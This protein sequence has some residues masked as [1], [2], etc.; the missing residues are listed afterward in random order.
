MANEGG[1][2]VLGGDGEVGDVGEVGGGV[3]E[4]RV[5]FWGD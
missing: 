3:G 1:V 5:G 2:G 4:G